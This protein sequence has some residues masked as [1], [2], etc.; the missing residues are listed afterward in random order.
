MLRINE[1]KLPLDHSEDELKQ[2]LLKRL[3]VPESDLISF[4]IFKRSYDARKRAAIL[5]I[6]SLDAEV[7]NEAVVLKR[8]S[9]DRHIMISPDI[10]YQYVGHAPEGLTDRPVVI[11]T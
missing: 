8:L 10:E 11:G 9:A 6:Y 1:V 3:A 2:A 4:T 7:K 5:L